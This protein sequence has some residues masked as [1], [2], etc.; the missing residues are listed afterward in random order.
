MKLTLRAWY[1][2]LPL[3]R[4]YRLSFATLEQ[5]DTFYVALEG[6][7]KFG[8]G[9]ITPLPGYGGETVE[10][11]ARALAQ[12]KTELAAGKPASE[13]WTQLAPD[14]PM[15]A[16][17]LACAFET[18]AEGEK[19]FLA[20]LPA[21]VPL[22]GLCAGNTPAEMTSEAQR[23]VKEGYSVFKLKA[24][25]AP[26]TEE[27]M[28][29]AAARELPPGGSMRLDANQAYAYDDAL[30]LCRRLED[31]GEMALLEQPFKPEMWAECARLTAST[32]FPIMLDESIWIKEEVS[33][34]VEVGA[35]HVKLK[36]CKHPGLAA[37]A[38][39]VAE[40]WRC[41]L[42]II[43]GNGVQTALGNH[44][45]ARLHLRLGLSTATE[46]NGFAKVQEHPFPSGLTVSQGQMVDQGLGVT[47]EAL[48][49]GRLVA[50]AVVPGVA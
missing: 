37:N 12:A 49:T 41:G 22:A 5:F 42:G 20:P 4:P 43:Y 50:E 34:A 19:A 33:R 40:A 29:R 28:A 10:G 24:G 15:T 25:R 17:G 3:R 18:W 45:E 6:E 35:K 47:I 38:A 36:L 30:E 13:V 31:L 46:A 26:E 11:A 7:G 39:L 27:I 1:H 16:S 48:A 21:G 14:Y 2:A 32:S 23:L 9:E 44:L 8:L